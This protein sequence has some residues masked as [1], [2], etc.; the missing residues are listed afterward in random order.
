M[1]F[2][3]DFL[4]FLTQTE[5]ID[6]HIEIEMICRLITLR[7]Y[8]IFIAC[9]LHTRLKWVL[10]SIDAPTFQENRESGILNSFAVLDL[11]RNLL[12]FNQT[13]LKQGQQ[14]RRENR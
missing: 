14:Q 13:L 12:L 1:S 7:N 4:H 9:R 6:V 2:S 5:A 3:V 11:Y 10:N 8:T